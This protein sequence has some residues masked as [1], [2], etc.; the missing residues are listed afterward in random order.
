M[1]GMAPAGVTR[2]EVPAPVAETGAAGDADYASAFRLAT[3]GARERTPE[4]WARA[5]FEGAPALLR[6]FLVF[7]WHRVLGLRL[8]RRPAPGYVLG[9]SM[10]DPGPDRVTLEAE[11][12]LLRAA[13]VALVDESSVTWVTLVHYERPLARPLWTVTSLVHHVTIPYLLA[14]ADR[15]LPAR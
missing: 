7:G 2:V 9:W 1:L 10:A 15:R 11:S 12:G 3:D 8:G 14:R 5:V 6:P 4:Q 13:N